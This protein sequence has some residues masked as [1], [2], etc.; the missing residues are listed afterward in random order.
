[1]FQKGKMDHGLIDDR[2]FNRRWPMDP[3]A[4][5]QQWF[6]REKECRSVAL[7][8]MASDAAEEQTVAKLERGISQ[9]PQM[10]VHRASAGSSIRGVLRLA[11]IECQGEAIKAR[12]GVVRDK[13]VPFWESTAA[14]AR[15]CFHFRPALARGYAWFLFSQKKILRPVSICGVERV[16]PSQLPGPRSRD[17][18]S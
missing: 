17:L 5:M 4:S 18:R 2:F 9:K 13:S 16:V 8:P 3:K 15:W 10:I 6:F 14:A 12:T 11:C 7:V 1:M